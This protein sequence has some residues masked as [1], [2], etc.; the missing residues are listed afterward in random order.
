MSVAS[1]PPPGQLRRVCVYCGSS[2]GNDPAYGLAAHA[3]GDVL[4]QHDMGLVYGGA[5]VGLMGA[6][7]DAVLAG[8]GEVI[9]VMP[10][11]LVDKEVAHHGLSELYVV[12]SMHERKALMAEL[13]DGFIA[14]PG[15]LG[16]LEEMFEVLTWAQLGF[17]HKPCG[18]LNVQGYYDGLR[19]FLQRACAEQFVKPE[20][21][22]ML[23]TEREP[24]ALLAAMLAYQPVTLDK[25]FKANPQTA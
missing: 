9:G 21:R 17:H 10:Q 22:D 23:L 11:A 24:A 8:G 16:T 14:L 15:G 5:R 6:V 7:A 4:L 18:L 20:H 19:Q 12:A 3:L 2:S 25:W 13:S 1:I